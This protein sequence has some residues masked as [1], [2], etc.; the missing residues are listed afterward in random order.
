[1]TTILSPMLETRTVDGI[2]IRL[3]RGGGSDGIPLLLTAPWPESIR[4][5]DAIWPALEQLGPLVAVDLPGFGLSEMREDLLSPRAMGAYLPTLLD[6][7]GL[8]RVHAIV[9]DVGTL[10]ALFAAAAYPD[11]FES[12]VGGSGGIAM[13]LL[14]AP[15]QQI[16]A[17]SR[18]DFA[19]TDGGAQVVSL[20]RSSLAL[21]ED[22]LEDYGNASAGSRW[23][24]AAD[25]VR[26]YARDLP[27]LEGLLGTIATPTLVISGRTDPFVPPANG[28]FLAEHLP[29]CVHEVVES[30]HFVW[31]AAPARYAELVTDWVRAGYRAA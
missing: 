20:I 30:G 12:I 6:A 8:D 29:H 17:S 25:F 14:G 5:F 7:L 18:A 23:N 3:R 16:V 19:G 21:P 15:L 26:A 1:M 24:E 10:A 27:A 11:R 9:P 22:V 31:E 28:A 13:P 4:A 2:R